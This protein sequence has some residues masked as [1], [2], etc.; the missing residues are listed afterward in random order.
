MSRR[1]KRLFVSTASLFAVWTAFL[2]S[3]L[4]LGVA[5][6]VSVPIFIVLGGVIMRRWPLE[7][8]MIARRWP[9]ESRYL[10]VRR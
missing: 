7:N 6:L 5:T 4:S 1:T 10:V 9:S 2:V 8:D 3:P